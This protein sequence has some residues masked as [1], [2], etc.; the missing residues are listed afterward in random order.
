MQIRSKILVSVLGVFITALLGLTLYTAFEFTLVPKLRESIAN[1][2]ENNPL[3][4]GEFL[5]RVRGCAGCHMVGNANPSNFGP[6]LA[7]I[8]GRTS[9]N[10]LYQSIVDPRA[11]IA[12]SCDPASCNPKLMPLYGEILDDKQ[13]DALVVYLEALK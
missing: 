1:V 6:N 13:I 4:Y 3:E 7:G 2:D 8:A 5:F 10:Y 9:T 12:E 11:V